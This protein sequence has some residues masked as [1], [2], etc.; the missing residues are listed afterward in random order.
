MTT[1]ILKKQTVSFNFF[2]YLKSLLQLMKPRVMSLVIFTCAVGLLTS[3]NQIPLFDSLICIFFVTVGA[4]AAGALNM[5]YEADLD[6]LMTRTC[7]RPIPTGKVSKDQALIFGIVLSI[8][9]IIGLYYFSNFLSATLLFITI[10]F[11]VFVYTIWLKRKTP[12]NIVIGGASG[13]LPPVIGWTIATNSLSLEPITFFL[14]IFYWTPSHFWALSLYKAKDYA[15]AK[16][17]MLPITNGIEETKKKIFV[18]SL[19]MIPVIIIPYAI[20][21]SGKLYI[22]VSLSLTLYYNYICYDLYKFKKNKFELNKAK[23]VFSYSIFY[24]FLLF[25]L[26]LVDQIIK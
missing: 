3:P 8:I 6:S 18:Y 17:P 15:K 11:Y 10:A 20:G 2:T 19:F 22:F 7:L 16:I 24:L 4:G 23:K 13:A 26:F 1:K 5:W 12:Q 25:V 21:F 9:S 14:I